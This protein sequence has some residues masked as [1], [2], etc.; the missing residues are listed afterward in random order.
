MNLGNASILNVWPVG[1][2]STI[3]ASNLPALAPLTSSTLDSATN[4]SSPGGGLFSSPEN[5]RKPNPSSRSG[6]TPRASA[7]LLTSNASRLERK[8]SSA[9]DGSTSHACSRPPVSGSVIAT[10]SPWLDRK[11]TSSASPREWAG[12]VLTISTL[13]S[14]TASEASVTAREDDTVVF[15]TPPFPPTNTVRGGLPGVGLD[16][17]SV[18]SS[19]RGR[20]EKRRVAAV[21][22]AVVPSHEGSNDDLLLQKLAG[23]R[24]GPVLCC[25]T[26]LLLSVVRLM[27]KASLR[28]EEDVGTWKDDANGTVR[29][30]IIKDGPSTA[31]ADFTAL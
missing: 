30:R 15:P 5:S 28:G 12:S 11:S 18:M 27:P 23:G 21:A 6:E 3:T 31:K 19:M 16:A 25:C 29:T 7:N 13:R 10:S 9:A 17:V 2:V 14:A 22:V 26:A 1:A 4:S 24:R 8:E 20:S